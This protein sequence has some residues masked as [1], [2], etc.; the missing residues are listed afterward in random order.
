MK[1][2]LP[3]KKVILTS[4]FINII[5]IVT[6]AV[7]AALTG[8]IVMVTE[9]IQ[10]FADLTAVG[11]V[12]IGFVRAHRT[13]TATHPLGFGRELYFWTLLSSI[14]MMVFTATITFYLGFLRF[15]NPQQIENIYLAYGIL[16]LSIATNGYALSLDIRKLSENTSKWQVVKNFFKSD[17]IEV[18]TTF[19]LDLMGTSIAVCGL[20]S[21]IFLKYT[22]DLRYDG[23][24]AMIMGVVLAILAFTL[25]SG[26]KDFLIGKAAPKNINKK[27]KDIVFKFDEVK[28]VK[29]L[30]TVYEGSSRL[31]LLIDLHL[32]D[33]LSTNQIE[34]LTHEVKDEIRKE[35]PIAYN[36]Q[37]EITK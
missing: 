17:H 20:I 26:A 11:L 36:I 27:I 29:N 19:T 24:G 9:S 33:G 6:N 34:K 1:K 28:E 37:I 25:F 2:E 32:K 15:I 21:L 16:V 35:L 23:L 30:H 5:D 14:L 18:K 31:L 22:G 8:S 7:I 10:G 3:V 4:L 12:Y 13:A